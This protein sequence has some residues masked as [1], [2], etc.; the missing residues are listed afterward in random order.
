MD[1]VGEIMPFVTVTD[2]DLLKALESGGEIPVTDPA[3]L[4]QLNDPEEGL[5]ERM[6]IGAGRGFTDVGEGIKQLGL[7]AGEK[8]GLVDPSTVADFNQRAAQERQLFGQSPVGRTIGSKVGR[9]GGNVLPA[10]AIPG[11][12]GGLLAR[13][14]GEAAIGGD[15]GATQFV[16]EGE[17]R[18]SNIATGAATGGGVA[19]GL[20]LLGNAFQR[21]R[22][23][24]SNFDE[25]VQL[26]WYDRPFK[27]FNGVIQ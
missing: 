7:Q 17:S 3:L 14:A 27:L 6:L 25:A 11:A 15:I 20:G 21:S 9:F 5:G 19:G 2:K 13:V 12:A 8:V 10:F 23:R 18:L 16:P 24:G 22:L 1:G 26:V 4:N